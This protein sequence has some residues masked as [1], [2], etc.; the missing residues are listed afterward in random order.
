M[1][2]AYETVRS[3][4]NPTCESMLRQADALLESG[5]KRRASGKAWEAFA[6]SMRTV[7]DRRG[8]ARAKAGTHAEVGDMINAA[9]RLAEESDAPDEI[10]D[11]YIIVVSSYV[12]SLEGWQDETSV[13]LGIDNARKA[14]T[15]LE[16]GA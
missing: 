14:I 2:A 5:D 15:R 8:W 4:I 10:H 6:H 1:V 16:M 7:M 3:A 13:K 9:S 11:I 12:N